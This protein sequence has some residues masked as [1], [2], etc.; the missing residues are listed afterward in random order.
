[1]TSFLGYTLLSLGT[2][3]LYALLACGVLIIRRGTGVLNFAQS[4]FLLFAAYFFDQ[5]ATAWDIPRALAGIITV[6]VTGVIGLAFHVVVMRALRETSQLNKVI[7]TL[8][9]LIILQAA[10]GLLFGSAT[11]LAPSVL[12]RAEIEL[13]GQLIGWDILVRL[14]VIA[15][16]TLCLWLFYRY[17]TYGHAATAVAENEQSAASLGWSPDA[18]AGMSW[19][20]GAAL[21]GLGGVL[22]APLQN[23]LSSGN[24]LLLIVPTLA[25]ALVAGF[26][27]FPIAFFAGLAISILELQIQVHS[28]DGSSLKGLDKAVPVLLIAVFLMIRGRSIP[29]RGHL[30]EKL[31]RLG[32][33][34]INVPALLIAS[35]LVLAMIWLVLPTTWLN[36]LTINSIWAILLLSVV[37]LVGYTG[38]LSLA[39]VTFAG[40]SALVAGR[41]VAVYGWPLE[42]AFVA[43]IV[44]VV[45]VGLL[46]AIPALRTRGIQLAV[47]T[48][49]MSVAVDAFF[50]QRQYFS[51]AP[52]GTGRSVF[53][54][55]LSRPE[56]T[57]VGEPT[58]FGIDID[59]TLHP[60][61]Y[62]TL[63]LVAAV[64]IGLLVANIRRGRVGRRLIAVRTNERAA[65]SLGISI[66]GAKMYAFALSA[67]IAGAGGV[68]L[69]FQ[70]RNITYGGGMFDPFQGILIIAFAVAGGVGY[71]TGAFAGATLVAGALASRISD[72][73]SGL[74]SRSATLARVAGAVLA[75]VLGFVVGQS[76]Q[77]RIVNNVRFRRWARY[78]PVVGL[79]TFAVLGVVFSD[80]IQG[81]LGDL[82]RYLPLVGG[83]VLIL[84]LMQPG[85]RGIAGTTV[86]QISWVS[87]KVPKRFR[88][89]D[90]G[91][92]EMVG[93]LAQ[94]THI[95]A[96]SVTLTVAGLG[97]RF[98]SVRAVDDVSFTVEAGKVVG[99]IGPNGAGKTSVVDAITGYSPTA[100]GQVTLGDQALHDLP[101]HKRARAG[102]SRSFQN[103]ELFEDLSVLENIRAASDDRRLAAY[104]TDLVH[105]GNRP[106]S[107]TAIAAIKEFDLLDDLHRPVRDLPY[108]RRR[109]VAIARAVATRPSILLLDEPAA[110]LDEQESAELAV[111]TRKLADEWN[112]GVLLIEHD[113][114]FVMEISDHVIVLDFGRKIAEGTPH[115]V[116]ADDSVRV[117]YFG[118]TTT[119]P[120]GSH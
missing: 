120:V 14:G 27:S 13:A 22:L 109:L 71:I 103:L 115:E 92:A 68:L 59:N 60:E 4:G 45:P 52:A 100:T 12:P 53:G 55:A 89:R 65:A 61:R 18:I 63:V 41:L 36:A 50:F 77:E 87:S 47:V 72:G 57:L 75:A 64:V 106:L 11:R 88:R 83:I 95:R 81:W 79:G 67:A 76:V 118:A 113:M 51:P 46:F 28:G 96:D 85:G 3:A 35:L 43:G 44:V 39:Q 80:R 6:F 2:G 111:L 102:V 29:E 119:E 9:L 69:A 32:S 56:G 93:Q 20:A 8:G 117:A 10:V 7:A 116:Q 15:A 91:R 34:R 21:A 33:G 84:V 99:L 48:L 5:L 49:G 62:A 16:I 19:F 30:S 104:A 58:L 1:M 78:A 54:E 17:T 26:T 108:G 105:P 114:N 97:V 101:A 38:Q 112:L 40:I 107:S 74:F 110:G 90:V 25:V 37:V 98:G 94:S 86:D 66:F 31:P 82:E 73:L 23:P 42:L 24:L 70:Q